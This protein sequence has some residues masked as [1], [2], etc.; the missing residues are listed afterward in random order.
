MDDLMNWFFQL[1]FV[2]LIICVSALI[3][4]ICIEGI[5]YITPSHMQ[6]RKEWKNKVNQCLLNKN[7]RSDCELIIYKDT[8]NN[9]NK[10]TYIPM[11]IPIVTR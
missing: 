7:Y 9:S 4:L 2:L 11:F 5:L 1:I 6:A 8:Q 3:I 10:N